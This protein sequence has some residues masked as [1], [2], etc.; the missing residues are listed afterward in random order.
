M[1]TP[2]QVATL[3]WN[4][5]RD[6]PRVENYAISSLGRVTAPQRD[7]WARYR[8]AGPRGPLFYLMA[9]GHRSLPNATVCERGCL[10]APSWRKRFYGHEEGRKAYRLTRR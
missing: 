6:R 5:I 8:K 9:C 2:A 3:S 4:P 10:I 1:L 7:R